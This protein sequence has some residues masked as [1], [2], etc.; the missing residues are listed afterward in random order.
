MNQAMDWKQAEEALGQVEVVGKDNNE[1]VSIT[2]HAE[3]LRCIGIGTDAAVFQYDK[4]PEYAFKVYS[5]DS[6][7][8]KEIEQSV[9][10]RLKG[11]PYFPEYHGTGKNYLV[12]S[13]EQGIT[14]F[15]CLLQGISVPKQVMLDVEEARKYVRTQGLNPRDIHLK[16]V[17]LQEGRGKVLDVSEY[18]KEGNDNRWEQLVWVYNNLYPLFEGVKVP[19]WILDAIKHWYNRIDKATFILEEFAQ[20][21]IKLFWEGGKHSK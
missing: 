3:G 20:K 16:N 13:Y 18:V 14:L 15:D 7:A 8:K 19:Y 17:L 21:A 10:Q 9:Y 5:K 6:L 11:S 4:I 2:V 1:L 12:L